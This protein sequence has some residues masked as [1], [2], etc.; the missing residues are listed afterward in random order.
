MYHFLVK[1]LDPFL[2]LYLLTG[3]ALVNLWRKRV[4][5]RRRLMLVSVP[6]VGLTLVCTPAVSHL[7]IGTL[8]WWY[9]PS[10]DRPPEVQA[11]VVLSSEMRPPDESGLEAELGEKS[12]YRCLHAAKLYHRG[13]PCP[14]L[15][16][17]GKVDPT[18]PGPTLAEL[19]GDLLLEL[20]VAEKDL[21]VEDRSRT[22]YE[23]A[24]E[25]TV[26]LRERGIET[27]QLVSDAMHLWRAE[28]CFRKQGF[29][30]VPSGC[31]YQ[32]T[33]WRW[34]LFGFLPSPSAAKCIER[35]THEWLGIVWYKLKGR[36]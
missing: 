5:S 24:A 7:A 27:I 18:T 32:A 11:I 13:R 15:V 30:V 29:E 22:T 20:G 10:Y 28:L 25:S 33:Q 8:E 1:L 34:R 2:I 23:N 21:I 14:V 35:V 36:I 6:F 26:L 19:M 17:G 12:L 4:E 9:P 3:L 16:S 31:N